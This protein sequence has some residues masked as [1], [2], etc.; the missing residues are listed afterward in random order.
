LHLAARKSVFL[1]AGKNFTWI[2]REEK[3]FRLK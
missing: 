1:R 2:V 3:C